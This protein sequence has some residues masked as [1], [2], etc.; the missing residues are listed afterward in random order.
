MLT[1]ILE[2]LIIKGSIVYVSK[3]LTFISWPS[4]LFIV[5]ILL[6]LINPFNLMNRNF[7]YELI[8]TFYNTIVA[9]FGYVRFKDFFLGDILTSMVKPMIDMMFIS[10][11]FTTFVVSFLRNKY[12]PFC[13]Y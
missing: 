11:Y 6:I 5:S 9:P 8:Y 2:A 10:C 4:L 3:D 13:P 12:P 1:I 7:R